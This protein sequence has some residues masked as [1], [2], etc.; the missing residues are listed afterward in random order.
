MQVFWPFC[1]VYGYCEILR[2]RLNLPLTSAYSRHVQSPAASVL[3]C[4]IYGPGWT[5]IKK[6]KSA[7]ASLPGPDHPTAY[8]HVHKSQTLPFCESHVV[9]VSSDGK[10]LRSDTGLPGSHPGRDS[11]KW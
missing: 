10:E 1:C 9:S 5:G 2:L 11:L 7:L 4:V 3:K 8:C 6:K